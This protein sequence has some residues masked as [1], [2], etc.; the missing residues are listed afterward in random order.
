[1]GEGGNALY[2][3]VGQEGIHLVFVVFHDDL[4]GEPSH[5]K[6]GSLRATDQLVIR[7][8]PF[9]GCGHRMGARQGEGVAFEKDP[10]A[11]VV[12]AAKMMPE[13]QPFLLHALQES[14]QPEVG[15]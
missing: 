2:A 15:E 4:G 7:I 14:K 6:E 8:V 9:G 12:I 3:K 1:M 5:A 10:L 13:T 11:G